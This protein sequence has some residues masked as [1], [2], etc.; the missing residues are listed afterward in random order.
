[1]VKHYETVESASEGA[2]TSCCGSR[3]GSGT[4]GFRRRLRALSC[5]WMA[6]EDFFRL[7]FEVRVE[8]R[9]EAWFGERIEM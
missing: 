1:V 4:C 6:V 2:R 5:N 3:W 7:G 9:V 8:V